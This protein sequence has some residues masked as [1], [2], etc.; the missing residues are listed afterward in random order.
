MTYSLI[1][2]TIHAVNN[3]IK[4]STQSTDTQFEKNNRFLFKT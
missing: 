2:C 3:F 1:G 4:F